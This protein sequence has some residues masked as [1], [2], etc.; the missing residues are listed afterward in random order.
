MWNEPTK[1]RMARIP[2]LYETEKINLKEKQIY[3]HFFIGACDWYVVEFDGKDMFWGYAI[4]NN[5]F[6][7]SEWGYFSLSELASININNI[8]IDCEFEEY[9]PVQ[10]A[11]DIKMICRGNGWQKR[12]RQSVKGVADEIR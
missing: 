11:A 2:K 5:D 4:L 3:L 1:K 8:E 7:M 12:T 10:K 9:F 6:E